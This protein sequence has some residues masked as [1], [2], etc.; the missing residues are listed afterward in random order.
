VLVKY[1][2][3]GTAQW[4]RTANA[5]NNYCYFEGVVSDSSG[6]VYVAGYQGGVGKYTYS[7]PG[8]AT[9]V[10]V[11]G[12]NGGP[13]CLLL[14]YSSDGTAQWAR[15]ASAASGSSAFKAVAIDSSGN[16]Y[17]AGNQSGTGAFDY[18]LSGTT[19]VQAAGSASNYNALLVKYA[20]S[21][22][23]LWAKTIVGGTDS[24]MFLG[25]AVD[26][27]GNAYAAGSQTGTG[28]YTYGASG[29]SA[30]GVYSGNDSVIVKY[31]PD[32]TAQ[33]ARTASAGSETTSFYKVA[34]DAGG[35]AYTVGYQRGT[36]SF[37]YSEVGAVTTVS[38]TGKSRA[39]NPILVKYGSDGAALWVKGFSAMSYYEGSG[40]FYGVCL[41][42]VG[43]AY[44]VGYQA[45]AYT[46]TYSASGVLPAVTATGPNA[47]GNN[48]VLVKY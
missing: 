27:A 37:T 1:S 44:A 32:G 4:A 9:E 39:M 7:L 47:S 14:K 30:T 18:S 41:D 13:N 12:Q 36:A 24:C 33:W 22:T 45:K 43:G 48:C 23:A 11:T 35:N 15:T 16:L 5:G 21:G 31:A 28:L 42:S 25:I 10:S 26:S 34:V 3:D 17:L 46:Y 2:S 20:P 40:T 19:S 29:V 38:L 6:N 8:A